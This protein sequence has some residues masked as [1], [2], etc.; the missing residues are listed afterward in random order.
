V[1]KTQAEEIDRMN[2]SRAE[3]YTKLEIKSQAKSTKL[4]DLQVE[5]WIV[6]YKKYFAN[7]K[8]IYETKSEILP[9]KSARKDSNDRAKKGKDSLALSFK[10]SSLLC[11]IETGA[12]TPKADINRMMN[13]WLD[14]ELNPS[15]KSE[16]STFLFG[17]LSEN[18]A[19]LAFAL[20]TPECVGKLYNHGNDNDDDD[21]NV[22]DVRCN[23]GNTVI[24][25]EVQ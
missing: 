3:L 20:L 8:L 21:N 17:R 4:D 25:V 5:K 7:L 22:A 15:T 19:I 12:I 16:F 23:F 1:S 11:D 10:Y 2:K 18:N 9:R 24:D 14:E 6:K 13:E